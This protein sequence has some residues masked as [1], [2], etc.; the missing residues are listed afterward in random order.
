MNWDER[1]AMLQRSFRR[2]KQRRWRKTHRRIDYTPAPEVLAV[3]ESRVVGG[4]SYSRAID[5]LILDAATKPNTGNGT[6]ADTAL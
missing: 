6:C 3:I 1:Y 4:V 5:A 2:D